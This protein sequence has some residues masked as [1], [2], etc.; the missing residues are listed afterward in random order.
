MIAIVLYYWSC[1]TTILLPPSYDVMKQNKDFLIFFF[2]F[3]L[4]D[5]VFCVP[6]DLEPWCHT[7]TC[8]DAIR[9]WNDPPSVHK[10]EVILHPVAENMACWIHLRRQ[11]IL[12]LLG[13]LQCK[14]NSEHRQFGTR[15]YMIQNGGDDN[16]NDAALYSSQWRWLK[17]QQCWVSV[18]KRFGKSES[19]RKLSTSAL[20]YNTTAWFSFCNGQW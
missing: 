15:R 19:R 8:V 13:V 12:S 9:A 11:N 1:S 5:L 7:L 16:A 4:V 3:Q 18:D 17:E 10:W 14:I 6:R 2:S 20:T